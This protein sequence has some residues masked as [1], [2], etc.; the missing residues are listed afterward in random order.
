M[1]DLTPLEA[2]VEAAWE[3]RAH[4][5]AATHGELS[6]SCTDGVC[7]PDADLEGR[8]ST[9]SA[10]AITSDVLG[11]VAAAAM[12]GGIVWAIVDATSRSGTS[13]A[14]AFACTPLGCRGRF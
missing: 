14:A 4:V 3:D 7:P 8:R 11:G 13:E 10:L 5:T 1:T 6:S 9:G 2:V 12:I